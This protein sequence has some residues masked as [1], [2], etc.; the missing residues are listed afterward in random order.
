ML[1]KSTHPFS[2]E[3]V[4]MPSVLVV[5]LSWIIFWVEMDSANQV[6]VRE[7]AEPG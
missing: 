2:L 5:A 3:Q 1:E 6:C 4:Y 7:P